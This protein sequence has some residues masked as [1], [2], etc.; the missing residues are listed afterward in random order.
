MSHRQ[1]PQVLMHFR[2]GARAATGNY[3]L[4]HIGVAVW[5]VR[6]HGLD[7]SEQRLVRRL[8]VTLHL[9]ECVRVIEPIT[10]GTRLGSLVRRI[11][12]LVHPNGLE[13]VAD[14]EIDAQH[15]MEG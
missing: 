4:R 8:E 2:I 7:E 14:R 3:H 6:G 1:T 15:W 12:N 13:E 9:G 5:S 11:K 10:F